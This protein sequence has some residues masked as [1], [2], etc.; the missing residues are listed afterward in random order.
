MASSA[1]QGKTE[2]QIKHRPLARARA[3]LDPR[4]FPV[5]GKADRG[6]YHHDELAKERKTERLKPSSNFVL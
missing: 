2:R 6:R 1:V 4:R 5:E 3:E